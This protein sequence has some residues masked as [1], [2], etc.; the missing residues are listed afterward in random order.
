MRVLN[1]LD[2]I[3][4]HF[5]NDRDVYSNPNPLKT[6]IRGIDDHLVIR[7]GVYLIGGLPSVGKSTLALQLAD[8]FASA[9]ANI[10]FFSLEQTEYDLT[11]KSINRI[12]H[13]NRLAYDAAI[14]A[15][16]KHANRITTAIPGATP[17]IEEIEQVVNE[18]VR[19]N[20]EPP[21]VF[22]DYLQLIQTRSVLSKKDS[23]SRVSNALVNLA[24]AHN[25][26][27]FVLSSLNR[28]NYMSPID[29][30]SFKESGSL[31]YDADVVLGLQYQI[32]TNDKFINCTSVDQK[33]LMVSGAKAESIRAVELVCLKNRFGPIAPVCKL[34]YHTDVDLFVDS[35]VTDKKNN[36][37]KK[38]GTCSF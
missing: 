18:Y 9:G 24:K 37:T 11:N 34:D 2:Y 6:G 21:I 23:V 19:N 33:R 12:K 38:K 31:E 22:I 14:V 35:A 27:M 15:Y 36:A 13:Q 17:T 16:E 25:I 26:T 30:E 1:K 8:Q 5:G 7:P 3:K 32:I 10:L 20:S 4:N 29:F 28:M